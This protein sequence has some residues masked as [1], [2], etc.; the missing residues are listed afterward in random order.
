MDRDTVIKKLIK[1][2]ELVF[3]VLI[4]DK[5]ILFGSYAKGNWTENS[6]IDVA[7]FV[8]KISDDFLHLSTQLCKLTRKID[9]RIEPVLLDEKN[10]KSGFAKDIIKHGITIYD[11]KK[12]LNEI[13]WQMSSVK[14]AKGSEVH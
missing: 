5:I 11:N 13:T 14:L 7:V 2:S 10:D 3:T 4:P 12:A 9:N 1:Y 6:D 8:D